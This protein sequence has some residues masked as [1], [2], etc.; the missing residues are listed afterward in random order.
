VG[1]E[2]EEEGGEGKESCRCWPV[3][4]SKRTVAG[5]VGLGD[6]SIGAAKDLGFDSL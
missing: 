5:I 3:A 6:S 4:G 1:G 2:R